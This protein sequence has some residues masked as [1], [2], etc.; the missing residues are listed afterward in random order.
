MK[1]FFDDERAAGNEPLVFYSLDEAIEQFDPDALIVATP[2]HLHLT[3]ALEGGKRGLHLLIEKPV[4]D[5]LDGLD[6]LQELVKEQKLTAMVGYNLRFHP[7]LSRVKDM[8]AAGEIGTVI[9]AS[10]E[11][12]ENIENW[13]PWEDYQDTYAPWIKSGGG[14]LLCFSHDIDYAYWLL[15]MPQ[16]VFA[17]GGKMT[18]LSGD[19][20]DLVESVWKYADK[21]AQLHIDYWQRPKVRTL[22]VIGSKKAVVWDAY[23]S[24]DVFDHATGEKTTHDV[25]QGF[26]RNTMFLD[27]LRHFVE[28]VET[29]KEPLTSLSQARDVVDIIERMKKAL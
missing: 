16:Q 9:S 19:A 8:V 1:K 29:K 12:G 17:A 28:C 3:D 6:V 25:P 23:G 4:H 13:H 2:N 11:V 26:E 21:T 20:E 27:E 18:P 7:L 22:K 15:G 14:A 24:L 5:S 10:V